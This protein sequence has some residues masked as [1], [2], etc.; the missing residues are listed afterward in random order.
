M[1]KIVSLLFFCFFNSYSQTRTV[2]LIQNDSTKSFFGYT[3]FS[4]TS[5]DTTYLIDI[6]G[7]KVRTWKSNYRP[8]QAV[9]LLSNG[10][11]L[12]TA[13]PGGQ[14]IPLNGGG[15]GGIVEK[16]NW[17][18]NLIWSFNQ[19]SS[20]YRSHH[21]VEILPN[22]NILLIVWVVKTK[23]EA[24]SVGRTTFPQNV[25]EIW[26]EKIIEVKPTGAN[27]GEIVWEWHA[28][29]HLIQDVDNAKP[30]FG[31]VSN[32]PELVNI[33]C[34]SIQTDWLHINSIRYNQK[35]DQIL[36]SVHNANEIWIID[37]STTTVEAKSHAGGKSGKGGD[38]L[39]RWGNPINY[40]TGST[41]DQKLFLQHDARW[42]DSGFVGAGNILIFNNGQ[43]RPGG[44]YSSI[45]EITPPVN[46]NGIYSISVNSAF[47]PTNT[48]WNYTALTPTDFY[49]QNIS[50]ASRLPNGNTLICSGPSGNFF[51]VTQ[52]KKTVWKYVNPVMQSGIAKQGQTPTN[53]MVFKIYRYAPNYAAFT[54][55]S[56]TSL[57]PIEIYTTTVAEKKYLP[58]NFKLFQNYPNPFNPTTKINFSL[59]NNEFVEIKIYDL[60]GNL[61][62]K[63]TENNFSAGVHAVDFNGNKL[64]SGVYF[65][66][67]KAGSFIDIKKMILLE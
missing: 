21:D 57:G 31:V 28:W 5:S 26:S 67:I 40:K 24:Q 18:G 8:G 29:D 45:E 55:R 47:G 38:L 34:A 9:M 12:R 63:L 30:N 13:T 36:L 22:G 60:L 61:V 6:N 16:Y 10:D 66:K 23:A 7:N 33:N 35:F 50:G 1:I 41:G 3:L 4:P 19:Y 58:E 44:N 32:H 15:A 17:S 42:I 14:T 56:L 64:N 2:G 65:Y 48:T 25:A 54:G 49:G 37:H 52:D 62:F 53:N 27:S 59:P 39:Y 20:T 43:G 11:L 51:E 46:A